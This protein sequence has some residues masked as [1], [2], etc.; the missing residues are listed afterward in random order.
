MITEHI[1]VSEEIAIQL[2]IAGWTKECEFGL[3]RCVT[4][5]VKGKEFIGCQHCEYMNDVTSCSTSSYT[6]LVA[7]TPTAQEIWDEV[8]DMTVEKMLATYYVEY[9]FGCNLSTSSN[10][11]LADALAEMWLLMKS[12]NLT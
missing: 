12:K 4:D 3:Y 6:E 1:T 8:G 10:V 9:R 11:S 7:Q 2:K 5:G